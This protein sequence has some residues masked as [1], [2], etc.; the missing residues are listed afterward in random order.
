M[1]DEAKHNNWRQ[2]PLYLDSVFQI[3]VIKLQQRLE[4]QI[5]DMQ[6]FFII[7]IL[8]NIEC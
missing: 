3:D 7:L 5:F 4:N 1:L 6:S 2:M 8:S